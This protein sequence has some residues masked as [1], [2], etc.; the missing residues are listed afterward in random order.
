LPTLAQSR[1][2]DHRGWYVYEVVQ[3][4]KFVFVVVEFHGCVAYRVWMIIFAI[5]M[6]AII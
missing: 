5:I 3:F 2:N 6:D 1:E 4:L